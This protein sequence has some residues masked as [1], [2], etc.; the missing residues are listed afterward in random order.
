[1]SWNEVSDTS[2]G[3]PS[4][5]NWRA[6]LESAPSNGAYE[7]PFYTDAQIAIDEINLDL[8]PY[9]LINTV[10]MPL[11]AGYGVPLPAIILRAEVHYRRDP[12]GFP[13]M[14]KTDD[15]MY[16]GGELEDE[17][18]ALVS[19]CLGIRLRAGTPERVFRPNQDPKGTPVAHEGRPA[20]VLLTRGT[21]P[22][23]P[24]AMGPCTLKD[25]LLLRRLP[26]LSIQQSAALIRAARLYQS[27]MWIAEVE[28]QTAW[29]L[30][31]SAIEAAADL[32]SSA[33]DDPV[34]ILRRSRPELCAYL[35]ETH[36]EG[37]L[38]RVAE[39]IAQITRVK[40]KFVQFVLDF[41]PTPPDTRPPLETQFDW[42]TMEDA[43]DRIYRYRSK[44]LHEGTPFP[45][46]M[47]EHP[48][49][50]QQSDPPAEV[51]LGEAA[52]TQG[53]T[54]LRK[55]TPMLLHTFEH[56]VRGALLNW[57]VSI[58]SAETSAGHET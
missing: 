43:L 40:Q 6:C 31:V 25:A 5:S 15:R 10:P 17:I 28:P 46:P 24:L 57:W 39:E 42:A 56:L 38:E 22:I 32:R 36:V 29:L 54:W 1:M 11:K 14:T 48:R 7:V 13:R 27:G 26:E 20:P 18:A 30:F 45:S 53:G 8:G 21:D 49:R 16:H 52:R 51:P 47:C 58:G 33:T 9:L 23:I 41:L 19:L 37:L 34:D 35:A 55:D 3:P 50:Y 2:Q 12:Y 4:Y 44:A